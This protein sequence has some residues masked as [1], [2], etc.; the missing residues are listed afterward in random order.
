MHHLTSLREF[1]PTNSHS[2][3]QRHGCFAACSCTLGHL[4][5][6]D[7]IHHLDTACYHMISSILH[8]QQHVRCPGQMILLPAW[9]D[10]RIRRR[11]PSTVIS[12]IA[13]YPYAKHRI[14]STQRN[15]APSNLRARMSEIRLSRAAYSRSTCMVTG[16]IALV[17]KG[18]YCG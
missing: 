3:P 4:S 15:H 18:N 10:R 11:P 2:S 6:A 9:P 7:I 17:Q 8:F 16:N 12:T 5:P 14:L 1:Q 13:L